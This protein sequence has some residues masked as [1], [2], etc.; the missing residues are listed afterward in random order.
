MTALIYFIV[1][2]IAAILPTRAWLAEQ[3]D[4]SRRAFLLLGWSVALTYLGFSFSLLP[5]LQNFRLLYTFAGCWVPVS[6]LWT[7]DR[8]FRQDTEGTSPHVFRLFL[9][10]LC[11][12]P[13]SL[14]L[15][16]TLFSDTLRASPVEMATNAFI[17]GAFGLTLYR[18]WTAFKVSPLPV[19]KVRLKYLLAVSA[20]ALVLTLVEQIA[21]N[22][23]TPVNLDTLSIIGR[24][25]VLQGAVPPFSAICT[26]ITLYFLYHSVVLSRLLDLHEFFSHIATLLFSAGVLVFVDGITFLWVDTFS[27]YPFHSTF[28][29]FL[30]SVVFLA[31]YDPLRLTIHRFSDRLF[32][33]RGQQLSDALES[34]RA[35]LPAV[36]STKALTKT[37]LNQL[38]SSGRAPIC[39]VYLW[40]ERT[41]AFVCVGSR[42]FDTSKPL[43]TV[44]V[45][46][47]TRGFA[48][49][50]PWYTRAT[51][52]RRYRA[53]YQENEI[54]TLMD[55]MHTDLVLPFRTANRILG[56]L[57]LRDEDWSDGYSAEELH[58]FR[59][60]AELVSVVVSNIREFKA[61]EEKHR[62]AAL[63]AMAAGL[64]HEIR[65]PL[66]GLK[67]AAQFLQEE[68]I[69]S[70]DSEM[71]QVIINEVNRLDLVVGEFLDYARPLELNLVPEDINT[72]VAHVTR[73]IK[74]QGLNSSIELKEVLDA[75]IPHFSLDSARL[76]QVLLNLF[77]NAVQSMPEG[78]TL[79][80]KTR[81]R[82][83][84][85][86]QRQVEVSIQDT[87]I[88]IKQENKKKLFLPFFTT[89]QNGTGLGL[90]ICQRIV[91]AHGGELDMRSIQGKGST[92]LVR[93][94]MRNSTRKRRR[95][96]NKSR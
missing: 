89:K 74:A 2:A 49:G 87:G 92:F 80:L 52:T 12:A 40:D 51:M 48:D 13:T 95:P 19:E 39:S 32:N 4:P 29:I 42:G 5:G 37:L 14:I 81:M 86:G 7:I 85:L 3:D 30:G 43:R 45:Q 33:Q 46:P 53:E 63:G 96:A 23:D 88:G 71:V 17:F 91:R 6:A 25:I 83:N 78:G 76:S 50:I 47:F 11:V 72:V 8:L 66:A 73:L 58:R 44:A 82:T 55:T 28:Q 64:A 59:N 16:T 24:G 34:L 60:L 38:R 35:A 93:L 68:P 20:A 65:N 70:G 18:I 69:I 62:L 84:R 67:G 90:A 26:G 54:L 77:Q 79:T 9:L 75:D 10:T 22:L 31:A 15:H 61:Q 21:R 56:W 1:A 36:T 41:D 57:N 27:D 94:P